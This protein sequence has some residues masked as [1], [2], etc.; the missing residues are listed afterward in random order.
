MIIG[1]DLA[2][3]CTGVACIKNADGWRTSTITTANG[4]RAARVATITETIEDLL[5]RGIVDLIVIEDLPTHGHA[6][7]IT[8]MVHGAVR[9]MIHQRGLPEPILVP[10]STLKVWGAGRGNATKID[11]VIEAVKR[12]DYQGRSNDE[13]DALWL[14]VLGAQLLSRPIVQLPETHTRALKKLTLPEGLPTRTYPPRR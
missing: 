6:A 8:G 2:L 3:G 12:L 1:L 9:C 11:M 14:A 4:T 7:G 5:G 10:P 13:V